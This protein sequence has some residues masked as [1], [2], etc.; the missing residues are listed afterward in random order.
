VPESAASAQLPPAR[1]QS[2]SVALSALE[3]K[4]VL[5]AELARKQLEL[6]SA[7]KEK[8]EAESDK[9]QLIKDPTNRLLRMLSKP[10]NQKL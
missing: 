7:Q 3:Q 6:Q 10:S 8:A 9:A 4:R 5:E 2:A 1:Q